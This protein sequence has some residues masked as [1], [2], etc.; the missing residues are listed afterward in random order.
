LDS[1]FLHATDLFPY[2]SYRDA[3]LSY[4]VS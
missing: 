4:M 3:A 1:L 2:K